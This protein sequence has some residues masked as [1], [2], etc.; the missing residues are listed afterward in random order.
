MN[1]PSNND[2]VQKNARTGLIVLAV[3]LSMIALAFASVPLYSLFCRVT[4]FGGTTQT[5]A[6]LPDRII[7]RTVTVKF[8]ADTG[9]NM[10]WEFKPDLREVDVHMGERGLASFTAHN[11]TD[12]PVAGTALYNVT[13]PKA[14]QYFHKIQC[15]CFDKQILT[16][17]QKM[18][19]PVMFFIDPAMDDDPN[20]NDVTVITLS[21]TFYQAEK[22]E[23]ESA[24]QGF[25]N[26]QSDDI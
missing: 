18:S 25:Y 19:M 12:T 15:F 17:G 23:L 13:P 5:A 6:A 1:T 26:E 2:L 22:E 11:I 8:N 21:Y 16:P 20:M 9:L 3:V 10:P 24:M 14:G 4:G 7:E